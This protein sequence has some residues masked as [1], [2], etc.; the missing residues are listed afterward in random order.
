MK[1]N[2]G[3]QPVSC[4][5]FSSVGQGTAGP[6]VN[7]STLVF[8]NGAGVNQTAETWDSPTNANYNRVR[9]FDL[10]QA[11]LTEAQ[12]QA[13]WLKV[14]NPNPTVRLPAQNANAFQLVTH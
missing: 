3:K 7:H 4:T 14:A 9:D 6:S 13:V 12:V 5:S 1:E 11:R 8:I 10:A 2:E